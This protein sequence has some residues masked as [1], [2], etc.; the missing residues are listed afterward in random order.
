MI[1]DTNG[2]IQ[3]YQRERLIID[4]G[5]TSIIRNDQKADLVGNFYG[6]QKEPKKVKLGQIRTDQDGRLIFI[7]GAGYSSSISAE[8]PDMQP[9]IVSEFDSIDWFDDACDGW[10]DAEVFINF[11]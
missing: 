6:S 1:S 4:P 5:P 2:V 10:V 8:K 7:G 3:P 11:G 9:D